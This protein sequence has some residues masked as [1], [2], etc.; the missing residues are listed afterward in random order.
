MCTLGLEFTN[1]Q[2]AYSIVFSL[3]VRMSVIEYQLGL[4]GLKIQTQFKQNT[5]RQRMVLEG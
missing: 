5:L 4:D 3:D 1:P 2:A